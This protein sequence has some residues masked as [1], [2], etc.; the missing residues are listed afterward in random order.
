M[1]RKSVALLTLLPLAAGPALAGPPAGLNDNATTTPIKHVIVIVG[2]NRSFD[3]MFG[4]YVSPHGDQ[5]KNILSEGIVKADGT[6]GPNFAKAV[7][8]QAIDLT[9]Y[10][11]SPTVTGAYVTLPP[12]NTGGT[13]TAQSYTFPPFPPLSAPYPAPF[14]NVGNLLG[15]ADYGLAVG[16]QLSLLTTGGSGLPHDSIDTRIVHA[17]ALP[18][19]PYP[20]DGTDAQH[21][22]INF[23]QYQGDL[24]HRFYQMFQQ[25]D[26][27]AAYATSSNPSGCLA[28]LYPWVE[29]T[30]GVGSNGN[31]QPSGF[32]NETTNEGALSMGFFNIQK[33][34]FPYLK[35]LADNYTILDNYHQ[36]A[37][38]GTGLDSLYLGFAD[39]IWYSD[40]Q[41]NPAIP[42]ANQIENPNPQPGTNNYYTQDGYSGGSY[43][44]CSDRTQPGVGPIVSYLTALHVDP[45]CDAAH[46]YIL[47]NYNPGYLGSGVPLPASVSPFTVPPSSTP[48]IADVLIAH[49]V[50][51]A[52]Y[53][54]G[55]NVFVATP[56]SP[57]DLYCNICNP[58]LYQTSIMTGT[59]PNTHVPY[60]QQNLLDLPNFYSDV[61]QNKLPA[62]S[63]V[64]PNG[65]NDGHPETSKLSVFEA[66][67][68]NIVTA[69]Q[70]SPEWASTA[71]LITVD[72]SGGYW[73][74]GY[75]QQLD[76]FG[77]GPRI[78]MIVVSPYSAGGHVSHVYGDHASVPKFIE[79]NW[80]L[81]TISNRSRDNLPNPVTVSNNPYVPT[82]GPSISDLMPVFR[83]PS[84]TP[85][86][87]PGH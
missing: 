42:P 16:G 56:T 34:N 10:S 18:S 45:K 55:W 12:P 2:E 72:E 32:T 4:T 68:K 40:G 85:H 63:Y 62:V 31:P 26:C 25:Q 17:N 19:G 24:V 83:L 60:R 14:G 22:G 77:D 36:P 27:S 65:L 3:H 28:D 5:I 11:I 21:P 8:R 48:S 54:E 69:V 57:L 71:I 35:S 43:S 37:K 61:A 46:Y 13:S 52:Y 51:W 73:D 74:S 86:P 1:L 76:F 87:A 75:V 44:N 49:N 82:N 33:N 38:G 20:L 39:D 58:F 41:G 80:G 78:P 84:N 47:N 67:V 50:S 70:A 79:A 66:F 64:K 6:P 59:D 9:N 7:Q 53:G 15:Y 30:I 29:T 23:D 81:P